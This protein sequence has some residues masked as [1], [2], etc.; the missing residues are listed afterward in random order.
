[1]DGGKGLVGGG[2]SS[3]RV[4]GTGA[5]PRARQHRT[6]SSLSAQASGRQAKAIGRVSRAW[7]RV[8]A[9][10]CAARSDMVSSWLRDS[11]AVSSA[12]WPQGCRRRVWGVSGP[13]ARGV[14][15]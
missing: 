10:T 1:M 4:W 5:L 13:M 12:C 15:G 7:R 14:A 6:R 2:G 3:R 8:P 11:A 9:R